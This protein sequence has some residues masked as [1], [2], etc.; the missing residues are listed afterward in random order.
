MTP[1]QRSA[2]GRIRGVL[3]FAR[4]RLDVPPSETPE[5]YFEA[6]CAE[7]ATVFPQVNVNHWRADVLEAVDCGVDWVSAM[8]EA[9]LDVWREANMNGDSGLWVEPEPAALPSDEELGIAGLLS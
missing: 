1:E 3:G 5:A 2:A 6:L 9:W 4:L 8:R 7:C